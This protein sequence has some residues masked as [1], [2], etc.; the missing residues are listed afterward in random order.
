MCRCLMEPSL[1]CCVRGSYKWRR[2]R[3]RRLPTSAHCVDRVRRKRGAPHGPPRSNRGTNARREVQ[4]GP[5][6][7]I[8]WALEEAGRHGSERGTRPRRVSS[9][10]RS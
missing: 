8:P 2:P 5:Q 6:A 10:L 3:F 7:S 1:R 4:R 9:G